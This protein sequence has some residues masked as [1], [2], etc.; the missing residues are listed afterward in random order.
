[1]EQV[2]LADVVAGRS[3]ALPRS[4]EPAFRGSPGRLVVPPSRLVFQFPASMTSVVVHG[5]LM[6]PWVR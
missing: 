4:C 5:S 3:K 2:S 6:V 1:M